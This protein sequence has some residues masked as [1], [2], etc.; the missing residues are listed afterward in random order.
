MVLLIL[1]SFLIEVGVL[2]YLEIKAWDTLFTPLNMLMLPYLAVLLIS[3]CISGHFGFITFYFPSILVWS[4]ALLVFAIPSL[5]LGYSLRKSSKP[6]KSVVENYNGISI[7]M[8]WISLFV[9]LG[10]FYRLRQ[11]LGSCPFQIGTD[12]FGEAFDHNGIWSHV[13]RLNTIMLMIMI[14]YLDK[15]HRY[16]WL[17]ILFQLV[18]LFIHKVKGWIFVPIVAGMMMRLYTGKSKLSLGLLVFAI[19]GIIGIFTMI[20]IVSLVFGEKVEM[21][22]TLFMFIL[23]HIVHY[24]TSGILGFSQD[25]VLGFPDRGPFEINI[26]HFINIAKMLTGDKETVQILNPLF[27]NTGINYTNVRTLFGTIFINSNYLSFIITVFVLSCFVYLVK[28]IAIKYDNMYTNFILFYT[29]SLLFMGWFDTYFNQL[30]LFEVPFWLM[31]LWF[32]DSSFEHKA[33]NVEQ[34]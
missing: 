14:Y 10:L 13:S 25:M 6:Y 16:I 34:V 19:L 1:I 29:C 27:I 17:I 8:I 23:R 12:E 4:T 18:L 24:L 31:V 7:Y 28:V 26:A 11:T 5:S 2:L 21:G 9:C 15:K 22:E 30:T 32:I 20:Y 33:T 3:V